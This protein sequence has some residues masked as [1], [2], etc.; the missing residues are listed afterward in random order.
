MLVVDIKNTSVSMKG[1]PL[2]VRSVIAH[3]KFSYSLESSNTEVHATFTFHWRKGKKGRNPELTISKA[4][5]YGMLSERERGAIA[6]AVSGTIKSQ[7]GEE[8]RDAISAAK[9]EF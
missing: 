8:V 9:I 2:A 7:I 4:T 5:A 6:A 1:K 3:G